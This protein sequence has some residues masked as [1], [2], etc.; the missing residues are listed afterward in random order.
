MGGGM[1]GG[2]GMHSM[3]GGMG[4]HPMGSSMAVHPMGS[5]PMGFSAVHPGASFAA[6]PMTRAAVSPPVSSWHAGPHSRISAS[7]TTIITSATS[8]SLVAR[9]IITPTTATTTACA[10]CGRAMAFGGSTSA[11]TTATDHMFEHEPSG[12]ARGH[13]L[14]AWDAEWRFRL[15]PSALA[16]FS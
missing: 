16:V 7:I 4:M 15:M 5:R 11:E 1:G 6:M 12:Q 9:P 3:G 13:V 10:E 8:S 14:L 2:M